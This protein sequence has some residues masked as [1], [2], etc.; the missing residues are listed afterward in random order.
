[1]PTNCTK[2]IEELTKNLPK[3]PNI[4]LWVGAWRNGVSWNHSK[5][6]AVDGKYL[7]TGG[8]NLWDAHYLKHSP[9][10]D[11]SCEL[12]GKIAHAGHNFANVHWAYIER[13][14]EKFIGRIVDAIV[15]DT[16]PMV[17]KTRVT[18]TAYPE[19]EAG[20]YPPAY[21]KKLMPR[22]K[23]L[24]PK[25]NC[26]IIGMGRK[27]QMFDNDDPSDSAFIAMI[28]SAKHIIRLGLQDLGPVCFP[29]SKVPLPGCT[30][31]VRYDFV[32]SMRF[33]FVSSFAV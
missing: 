6:I 9:V 31:Y 16:L 19:D 4:L 20:E 10:H 29:G 21:N 7:H 26:R 15:P 8:H 30:W 12:E 5:I 28:K 32:C 23:G 22:Y 11:L 18:I 17:L 27:G 14:Q 1:M 13:K 24:N 2:V 25:Y 3:N 33:H